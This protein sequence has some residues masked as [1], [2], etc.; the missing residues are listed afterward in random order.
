ME[1]KDVML[2]RRSVRKFKKDLV[3]FE[4]IDTLLHYGMSG[5]SACNKQTWEFYVVT[6]K[7]KLKELRDSSRYTNMA[8]PL[9]II[10]C[11]ALDRSL[12]LESS[13]FWIQDCSAAIENILLGVTDL[14]LGAVWCGLHPKKEAIKKVRE[15]LNIPEHHV[16]LGLLHIG[17]PD[18]E[19]EPRDW[20]KE[21]YI[22][23]V[24]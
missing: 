4:Q 7:D 13:E 21:E 23:Y 11:G 22:H 3:S 15:I 10:V 18:C 16:P 17:Y 12:P 24:K 1:L 20:Y 14:G 5:P 8:S 2:K 9:N 19:V 6:N